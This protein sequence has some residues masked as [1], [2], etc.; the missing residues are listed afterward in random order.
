MVS[1]T[2]TYPEK[3]CFLQENSSFRQE[4]SCFGFK[5]C[6]NQKNK[7]TSLCVQ[8]LMFRVHSVTVSLSSYE[9]Y[10]IALQ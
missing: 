4:N 3:S 2:Y 9:S 10:T 8:L 1:G 5:I 6:Y 7:Y